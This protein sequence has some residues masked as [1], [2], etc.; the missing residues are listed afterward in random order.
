V[1]IGSPVGDYS[2][3][4]IYEKVQNSS[5]TQ[6]CELPWEGRF[7]LLKIDPAGD[8]WTIW[9]DWMGS[10]PIFHSQLPSGRIAST[11]EPVVVSTSDSTKENI[12]LPSLLALLLWGHY[13]SDWTLFKNIKVVPPDC[14][15]TW[16]GQVFQYE[17]YFTVTPSND[18][19]EAG[20]DDLIDEMYELSKQAITEALNT[21]SRWIL[22]LSGGLDSRLIAGVA[23]ESGTNIY[24][25]S[26]GQPKISD[27][28][29]AQSIAQVLD[30][31]W[32]RVDLGNEY[33][34]SYRQLWADLFGSA[35]H[36]HGMYQMPFLNSLNFEPSAPILSGFIG[37][38]L[39]GYDTKIL[40]ETH[41]SKYPFQFLPDGY[42]HWTIP[43][44][45]KLITIPI[46]DAFDE[47]ANEM[48]NCIDAISGSLYQRLR[49][50]TLWGRQRHFTY[51]QSMLS[52][53]WRGVSTPY[54]NR[55]YARFSFALPRAV[56]DNRVLQ[57]AMMARY[58]PRLAEIPGTY[59]PNPALLTGSYFLK[60]RIANNLP[61]P[62]STSIFPA[63]KRTRLSSDIECVLNSKKESFHPLFDQIDLVKEWMNVDLIEEKYEKIIHENDQNAV[64]KLQSIQTLAFRLKKL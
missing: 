4:E 32:K 38:C 34:T 55:A 10:I 26:W 23:A 16:K 37:E 15:A 20:W 40:V 64:R 6:C 58:Y 31:P 5:T 28:V 62:I 3:Q 29:H 35:M 44:L 19:M 33:L 22:P 9:N 53:Y 1:L 57:Q 25:Y 39:A 43:E 21:Q 36:F 27:V 63:F 50:N 60:K 30:I 46:E 52:D 18:R 17:Q 48:E 56:L 42:L 54:I 51:F 41:N 59:A 11:L 24:A 14:Q 12:Y 49:L 2:W 61:E 45:E 7:I 8:I 47:L 13:F